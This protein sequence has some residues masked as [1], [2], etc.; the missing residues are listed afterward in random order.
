MVR[1]TTPLLLLPALVAGLSRSAVSVPLRR[2]H[3]RAAAPLARESW[4][5]SS[6]ASP[7]SEASLNVLFK[8][9]PV[10]YAARCDAV[11]YDRQVRTMFAKWP[12]ISRELAEQE[13]HRSIGEGVAY[14]AEQEAMSD[15]RRVNGPAEDELEPPVGLVEKALVIAWVLILIP[16]INFLWQSALANPYQR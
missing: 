11:E 14:L 6:E 4:P 10:V 3:S 5:D 8:Y 9:G 16:S 7:F 2:V 12:N 13:V 1:A 15:E